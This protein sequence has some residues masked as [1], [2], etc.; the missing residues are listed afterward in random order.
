MRFGTV[1]GNFV[2][3]LMDLLG[4]DLSGP[5]RIG[6]PIRTAIPS[7]GIVEGA[8]KTVE[9][10]LEG[11]QDWLFWLD[12]DMGFGPDILSRLLHAADPVNRPAVGALVFKYEHLRSDGL[13]GVLAEDRPVILDWGQDETGQEGF[14]GR[15]VYPENTVLRCGATGMACVVIHRSVHEAILEND[16]P[17]WHTPILHPTTGAPMG[18]DVS[19]WIRAA[20]AGKPLHVHTGAHTNHAKTIFVGHESYS[21]RFES[22]G[23]NPHEGFDDPPEMPKPNRAE[24]RKLAKA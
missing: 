14:I 24:R 10:F 5:H 16:G 18:P 17:H 15:R 1:T 8:N 7:T 19:F 12:C 23:L 9:T 21:A 6:A 20:A 2:D 11:D 13:N 3:S 4:Y 22:L